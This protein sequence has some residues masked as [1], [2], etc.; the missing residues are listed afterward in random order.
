MIARPLEDLLLVH[1]A[2]CSGMQRNSCTIVFFSFNSGVNNVIFCFFLGVFSA[3][4]SMLKT[5]MPF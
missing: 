5:L 4:I 1:F 3:M 2:Y